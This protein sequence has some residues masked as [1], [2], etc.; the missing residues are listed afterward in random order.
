VKIEIINVA[1]IGRGKADAPKIPPDAIYIGRGSKYNGRP[2]SPLHN[3]FR[4]GV[5]GG[6]QR[7][8]DL[9][10][11]YLKARIAYGD[12]SIMD[13]MRRLARILN[14]TKKLTLACWCAP[15]LCHG[16]VIADE[17]RSIFSAEDV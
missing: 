1:G 4:I 17:L 2:G 11:D 16:D 5:D 13:E 7:C 3:P 10:R 9:Y 6:R 8:V 12:Q 14:E 15:L